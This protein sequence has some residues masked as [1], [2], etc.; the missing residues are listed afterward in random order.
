VSPAPGG[1]VVAVVPA[2]GGS[3]GIPRKNL[4]DLGGRPLLAWS[5]D[6]ALAAPS[7]DRVIVS[8]DDEE[9]AAVAREL[10]AEVPFLRPSELAADDTPALPVFVH[11]LDRFEAAGEA[12]ELLVHLRPTSP[13]R[14]P[15]LI[16]AAVELL[17]ADPGADSVRSLSAV[18]KT[19]YKMWTVVDGRLEPLLGGWDDELFNRPRQQLPE[20]W[21][22][23][24]VLDVVRPAT[25]RAGSMC[26]RHVLPLFTPDGCAVDIDEPADLVT[27]ARL[28]G[29][30]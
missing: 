22:H 16:D 12:P 30:G 17:R 24:G 29:Y 10:G 6:A 20:V 15:G 3:K 25:L 18:T 4:A 21:Q 8:T 28:L 5:V 27:A 2:R 11:A 7:V 26:G 9:I 13:L 23:D 14:P 1:G 19:P